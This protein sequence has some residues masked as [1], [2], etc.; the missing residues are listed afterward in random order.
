MS[1]IYERVRHPR[2]T[3]ITALVGPQASA[4]VSQISWETCSEV[5]PTNPLE[6]RMVASS[7]PIHEHLATL[8]MLTVEHAL[9]RTVEL[10][11]G[12]G[13]STIALLQAAREVGGHVTS[14]DVDPCEQAG[15]LVAEA[16][17]LDHWTFIQG[18]DCEWDADGPIDHLFIDTSH[19]FDH[20]LSELRKYEPLVRT[21]G[22]I[23]LHDTVSFPPVLKAID[24]YVESRDDL[25][26][27]HYFNCNGLAV[28]FKH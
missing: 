7:S 25:H 22:L 23:T 11:C 19:T 12:N 6:E 15:R 21:G 5:I 16:G 26:L 8:H 3:I 13:D 10:G 18:D 24:S 20:T 9:Q 1:R 4:R 17:L 2:K 28:I 27:Y 14:L